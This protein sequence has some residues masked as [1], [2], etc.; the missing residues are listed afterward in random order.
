MMALLVAT[1]V[2]ALLMTGL[3]GPK[4]E[5]VLA[6]GEGAVCPPGNVKY[7]VSSGYEY[8]DGSV[9][10]W[11]DED[12]ICWSVT[13]GFSLDDLCLKTGGPGGGSLIDPC[14]GSPCPDSGCAGPFDYGFSHAVGYTTEE[15]PEEP[16]CTSW[17]VAPTSGLAPLDVL[18]TGSFSDPDSQVASTFVEWGDSDT[19]ATGLSPVNVPHTYGV[20]TFTSQLVLVLGDGTEIRDANCQA[21]VKTTEEQPEEPGCTLEV[22]EIVH[23]PQVTLRATWWNATAGPHPLD[24]DDGQFT[25]LF[26]ASGLEILSHEYNKGGT[27]E[28]ELTVRGEDGQEF[29]CSARIEFKEEEPTQRGIQLRLIAGYPGIVEGYPAHCIDR[30]TGF[31]EE[32]CEPLFTFPGCTLEETN[33]EGCLIHPLAV[34]DV[35]VMPVWGENGETGMMDAGHFDPHG[36]DHFITLLRFVGTW[37]NPL[38]TFRAVVPKVPRG[39]W[40]V[41]PDLRLYIDAWNNDDETEHSFDFPGGYQAFKWDEWKHLKPPS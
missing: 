31:P 15:Q 12:Q 34:E 2:G 5:L 23:D 30:N 26:G 8:T 19:T 25:Q 37:L 27:R 39:V 10:I 28:V 9:E 14:G 17:T 16:T 20:G 6:N 3:I 36:G 38:G 1:M 24:W 41:Y 11:G 35:Y 4:P 21:V 22:L 18:G 29:V 32:G 40:P 33:D 7:E 13:P